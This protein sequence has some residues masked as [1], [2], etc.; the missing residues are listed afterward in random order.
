MKHKI[1]VACNAGE[2][3]GR[4]VG[5]LAAIIAI[6]P[7][8]D[9]ECCGFDGLLSVVANNIEEVFNEIGESGVEGPGLWVY[10]IELDPEDIDSDGDNW[11]HLGGGDFRRPTSEEVECLAQGLS[12]WEDGRLV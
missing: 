2:I 11:S 9:V 8:E 7:T 5:F 12:P 10:E 3:N 6:T 4:P 1:L